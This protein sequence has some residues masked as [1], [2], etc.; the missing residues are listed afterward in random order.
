MFRPLDYRWASVWRR[1]FVSYAAALV[2]IWL[3]GL[4]GVRPNMTP[5]Q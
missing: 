1:E 4:H 5:V 2:S 3:N